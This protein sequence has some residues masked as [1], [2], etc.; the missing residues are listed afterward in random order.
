MEVGKAK[1]EEIRLTVRLSKELVDKLDRLSK[2]R[3]RGEGRGKTIRWIIQDAL[4]K[5]NEN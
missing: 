2:E 1:D 4:E 5:E 3:Y